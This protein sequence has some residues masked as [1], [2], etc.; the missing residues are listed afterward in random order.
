MTYKTKVSNEDID[1]VL[2]SV[3]EKIDQGGSEYPGMSYE[4]GI[5]NALMW[6]LG[7]WKDHPYE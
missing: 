7:M 6:V 1:N 5:Q 4:Q 3:A 2:N